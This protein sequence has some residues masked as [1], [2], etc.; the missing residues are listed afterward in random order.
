MFTTSSS[1]YSHFATF[2]LAEYQTKACNMCVPVHTICQWI[3]SF[4][5]RLFVCL[6]G[7]SFLICILLGRREFG[8]FS[9]IT[10]DIG[11]WAAYQ[12]SHHLKTT[13]R[14]CLGLCVVWWTASGLNV[15]LRARAHCLKNEFH[16]QK[17]KK[18]DKMLRLKERWKEETKQQ[19]TKKKNIPSIK[20]RN[21]Q[22]KA[23]VTM[24]TKNS[25]LNN[26]RSGCGGRCVSE[27]MCISVMGDPHL[28]HLF[29]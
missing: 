1:F 20:S 3:C 16:L 25:A 18:Y 12:E 24:T 5:F 15:G 10:F 2:T 6:F 13:A 7:N 21:Q 8:G 22:M 27:R 11:F 29:R 17:K 28:A 14:I 4:F 23:N 19:P 9:E 26:G